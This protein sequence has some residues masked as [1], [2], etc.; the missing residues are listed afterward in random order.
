M[1]P[2]SLQPRWIS[3][4]HSR[5]PSIAAAH[6]YCIVII[7]YYLI[8]HANSWEFFNAR[9]FM[10][11][12]RKIINRFSRCSWSLAP[13]ACLQLTLTSSLSS[14]ERES[15]V[16]LNDEALRT[17]NKKTCSDD[18]FAMFFDVIS[19]IACSLHSFFGWK[20]Y[21]QTAHTLNLCINSS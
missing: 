3:T 8:I 5:W 1:S 13:L 21:H 7:T 18:S 10:Q 16:H 17:A 6:C 20:N 14:R 4:S 12:L 2:L 9:F 11:I 19:F 15:E